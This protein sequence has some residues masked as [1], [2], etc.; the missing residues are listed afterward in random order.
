MRTCIVSVPL[1]FTYT[2][3]QLPREH[4]DHGGASEIKQLP[5]ILHVWN[6]QH[7]DFGQ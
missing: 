4:D 1:I 7:I 2:V 5:T 6:Q 3:Q